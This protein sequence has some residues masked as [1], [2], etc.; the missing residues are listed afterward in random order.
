MT[1]AEYRDALAAL[2]LSQVRAA[3]LFGVD[4]R[5]SRRWALGEKPVPRVVALVLRLMLRHGVSVEDANKLG[6]SDGA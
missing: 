3:S 6:E 4:A 1:H 5:T 2:S